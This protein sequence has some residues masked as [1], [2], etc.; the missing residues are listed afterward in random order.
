PQGENIPQRKNKEIAFNMVLLIATVL[1]LRRKFVYL[2]FFL[3]KVCKSADQISVRV[4]STK[5]WMSKYFREYKENHPSSSCTNMVT[6]SSQGST[7]GSPLLAKRKL[8]DEL[9]RYKT[10][11][12]VS[13]SQK[14][15]IE[16]YLE[17]E[18]ENDR[19]I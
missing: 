8:E 12:R 16:V 10:Q 14:S 18:A 2:N 3:E 1:D 6:C 13:S 4:N 7:V 17:E 15:E 9:A 19:R 11:V 5:Q